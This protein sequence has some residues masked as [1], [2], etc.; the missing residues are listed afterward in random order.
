MESLPKESRIILAL[1]AL[2]KT[3]SFPYGRL[4]L[5]TRP[6][7]AHSVTD[8]PESNHDANYL[9]TFDFSGGSPTFEKWP[10]VFARHATRHALDPDGR[11]TS[12]TDMTSLRQVFDVESITR[13]LNA[14][15]PT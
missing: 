6:E 4:L 15:I 14:K 10:I 13:G 7:E 5:S 11:T 1:E 12:W 3:L 2:K 8:A 9:P